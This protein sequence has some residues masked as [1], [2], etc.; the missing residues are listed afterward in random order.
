M[1]DAFDKDP[2]ELALNDR[3]TQPEIDEQKGFAFIFKG[4]MLGVR[5]PKA[6]APF[7]DLEERRALDYLALA[8][9]LMRRLDDAEERRAGQ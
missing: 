8:S 5:D 6:H 9:L 7:E 4:A 1:G 3:A 2:P